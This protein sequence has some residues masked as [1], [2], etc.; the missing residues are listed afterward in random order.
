MTAPVPPPHRAG[1]LTP[2][3]L[4]L[5]ARDPAA[6]PGA[7]RLDHMLA[8]AA[9]QSATSL[10]HPQPPPPPPLPTT[11]PGR[12]RQRRSP[13]IAAVLAVVAGAAAI[14]L[15]AVLLIIPTLRDQAEPE[16]RGTPFDA[17]PS[18]NG[19]TGANGNGG[20]AKEAT[21]LLTPAAVRNAIKKF[22]EASGSREFAEF[23][24]YEKH[25]SADAPVAGRR[26]AFDNYTYQR[27]A[28]AA[29]RNR[30]SIAI[31]T[32]DAK[33]N[34]RAFNW[35]ALPTLMNRAA[36]TLKV[37]K[38]TNRYVIVKAS[39]TFNGDRPTMLVYLTD[40][41]GGGYLAVNTKGKVIKTVPSDS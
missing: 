37:P 23:T 8:Q 9:G 32:G 16:T 34:L 19:R 18:S 29:V 17:A 38:P 25:A 4:A 14:F 15:T 10:A 7:D 24:V 40:D 5:L 39:W 28:D 6:R 30:P 35:D 22:E 11:H 3:L 33:V 36:R 26:G 31:T 12:P 41:Y 1:P 13:V 21:S 2:V 20:G 27:G